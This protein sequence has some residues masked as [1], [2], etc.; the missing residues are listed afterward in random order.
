MEGYLG[1]IY[2]LGALVKLPDHVRADDEGN[3]TGRVSTSRYALTRNGRL[4][5]CR[6]EAAGVPVALGKDLEPGR[7]E[8]EDAH[9][10][11]KVRRVHWELSA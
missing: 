10:N 6:D 1:Q 9:D 11:G 2:N 5:I 8:D 4:Q 7:E 3:V